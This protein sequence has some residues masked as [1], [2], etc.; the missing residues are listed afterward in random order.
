MAD[1]VG[2][3]VIGE[4]REITTVPA[5]IAYVV[6]QV[7]RIVG[8]ARGQREFAVARRH[9]RE[10]VGEEEAPIVHRAKEIDSKPDVPA[11]RRP[12]RVG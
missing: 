5:A 3:V 1:T 8:E 7:R 12:V 6:V 9:H 10:V 4:S 11:Q 2:H